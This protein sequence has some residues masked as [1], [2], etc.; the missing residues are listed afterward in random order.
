MATLEVQE[1]RYTVGSQALLEAVS[2]SI[3]PGHLTAIIGPNGAGKTTFLRAIA[4]LLATEG[5]VRI[6]GEQTSG[7]SRKLHARRLAFVAADDESA[8]DLIVHDVV[9][10]GRYA[11]R[12][13]AFDRSAHHD[14]VIDDALERTGLSAMRD[15]R[16]GELSSGERRRCWIA[17]G[18]AQESDILLLDE[19]TANLDINYAQQ[20]LR[21]LRDLADAGRTIVT[22]LHDLNEAAQYA[23][24]IAL[25]ERGRLIT[26]G[27]PREVLTPDRIAR[28]YGVRV[29]IMTAIDGKIRVFAC[30]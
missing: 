26:F 10:E 16:V 1:L 13:N 8:R 21:I 12:R 29:E 28:C 19:P 17:L 30:A 9:A 27:T 5:A 20:T 2:C 23:D 25:V 15:R 24:E 7:M 22:V 4:G 11:Y 6:D 18:L 3:L 14:R